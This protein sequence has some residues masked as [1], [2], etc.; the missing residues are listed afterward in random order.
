MRLVEDSHLSIRRKNRPR[1]GV[2]Y[3]TTKTESFIGYQLRIGFLK[4]E[5]LAGVDFRK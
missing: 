4:Y 2:K 1:K 5:F 3:W